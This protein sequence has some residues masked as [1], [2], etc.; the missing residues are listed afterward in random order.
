MK[1]Y[2]SLFS[3]FGG[4]D[5][6]MEAAGLEPI[7]AFEYCS[8]L[9]EVGQAN[10][11]GKYIVQDIR[12][13]RWNRYEAPDAV[14]MSPVCTNASVANANAGETELD[15]ECARAAMLAV[16]TWLPKA[17]FVENVYGYRHFDSFGIICSELRRLGYRFD[18]WH[19]N[20]ADYGVPQTRKRLILIARRDGGPVVRPLATHAQ[21]PVENLFGCLERWRGWYEAIED[22]IP[23]LPE[24]KFADWQLEWL[25]ELGAKNETLLIGNQNGQC[26]SQ[27]APAFTVTAKANAYAP[28][29]VRA[30][31][32][33]GSAAGL[34][35]KFI[36]PVRMGNEPIF[37]MRSSQN[38]P[39]AFLFSTQ[40]ASK[41][42]RSDLQPAF[43][44]TCEQVAEQPYRAQFESG[45]VV[46]MTP[47]ALARFQSF[48]DDYELPSNRKL[49]CTG[50]GNAVPSLLAQRVVESVLGT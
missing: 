33:E 36:P 43:T 15:K 49:A 16:A 9:A 14:W 38:N 21:N 13:V 44:A 47:R 32:M 5:K 23:D 19:L 30:F 37:T 24:S 34:N 42:P 46:A 17:V 4:A 28:A 27:Y 8:K 35:N 29:P 40:A 22:L 25:R 6:G 41:L 26:V 11:R 18:F 39:R 1:T 45:R 12:E 50:V 2:S 31:I 10:S 20:S 3:G 48:P 7:N